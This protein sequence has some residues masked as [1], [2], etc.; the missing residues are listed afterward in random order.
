MKV[1]AVDIDGTPHNMEQG[2]P[3]KFD[4]FARCS[5]NRFLVLASNEG[6]L[7]NPLDT[8]DVFTKPDKERGGQFWKLRTCSKECYDRYTAF[9]RCKNKTPF[10]VAQRRFRN[11]F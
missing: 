1:I 10:L 3:L 7:F 9:L 11:D 4:I 6:D 5:G 2:V 8:N